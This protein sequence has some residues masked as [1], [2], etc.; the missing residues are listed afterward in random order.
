MTHECPANA[1]SANKDLC[2]IFH[3]NVHSCPLESTV[4]GLCGPW[5]SPSGETFTHS[6]VL[7]MEK[8]VPTSLTTLFFHSLKKV[9]TFKNHDTVEPLRKPEFPRNPLIC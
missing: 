8:F 9:I 7:G 3:V 1:K 2:C 6:A 5:I 4:N